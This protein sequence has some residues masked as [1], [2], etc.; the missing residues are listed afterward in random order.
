[1]VSSDREPIT[2]R[3]FLIAT[4]SAV[5]TCAFLDQT[6]PRRDFQTKPYN[7]LDD[8]LWRLLRPA[9]IVFGDDKKSNFWQW[10]TADLPENFK[11]IVLDGDPDAFI[12]RNL[13]DSVRMSLGGWKTAYEIKPVLSN[14]ENK[15]TDILW[16]IGYK[17]VNGGGKIEVWSG[18]LKGAVRFLRGNGSFVVYGMDLNGNEIPLQIKNLFPRKENPDGNPLVQ[19]RIQNTT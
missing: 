6:L 8:T 18:V 17:G 15:D 11:G 12:R 16:Q 9:M 13:W 3:T 5:A 14:P 2:R 1:M 10:H 19:I 7:V 4:V